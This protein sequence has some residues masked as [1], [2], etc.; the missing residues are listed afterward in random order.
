MDIVDSAAVRGAQRES[1]KAEMKRWLLEYV[2]QTV[3]SQVDHAEELGMGPDGFRR[4]FAR[5][6]R[7]Y[8]TK[9]AE[10]DQIADS[11]FALLE[12]KW[13]DRYPGIS[14][15]RFLDTYEAPIELTED[16]IES[17]YEVEIQSSEAY[18]RTH[19]EGSA[20]TRKGRLEELGIKPEAPL[21][22][23]RG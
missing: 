6:L 17:A 20:R 7:G 4:M 19:W 1:A 3:G 18:M 22:M 21:G 14:P 5:A 12:T 10:T 9:S 13:K 23:R 16:E 2:I 15:E 8:T 11:T